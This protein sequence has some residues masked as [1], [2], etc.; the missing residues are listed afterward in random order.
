MNVQWRKSTHSS[1]V[2]DEDCVELGQLSSA[3]GIRDSKNPD[4]GHLTLTTAEFADLIDRIK[5]RPED[6]T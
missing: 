6:R 3:I 5:H 4:G 2:N 1:G